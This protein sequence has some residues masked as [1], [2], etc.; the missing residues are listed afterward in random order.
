MKTSRC[1]N[2]TYRNHW[3]A[4]LRTTALAFCSLCC[5]T[6]AHADANTTTIWGD[7]DEFVRLVPQDTQNAGAAHTNAHPVTLPAKALAFALSKITFNHGGDEAVP[8]LD[9][10]AV[11][12]IAPEI[13]KALGR[14]SPAQDVTFAINTRAPGAFGG[15]NVVSVAGRVFYVDN[16]LQ[17]IVG[18]M[19]EST[20]SREF[21]RSPGGS[22]K[23][24]RRLQ[25]HRVGERLR[26][27]LH[28]GAVF[29]SHDGVEA[30]A[31]NGK[32]R[33]DWIAIDLARATQSGVTAPQTPR[34]SADRAPAVTAPERAVEPLPRRLDAE[35][36]LLQLERLR[37]RKLIT[38][39]EYQRKRKL[40]IDEL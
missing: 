33:A 27:T 1:P 31:V 18:E 39:E 35:E 14:A 3:L 36:R 4:V 24:D 30:V 9:N 25:P 28:D 26:E 10:N 2:L 34:G 38:E 5:I 16:R 37:E 20:V 8:L 23:I 21:F 13:S 22:L 6:L 17:M 12:R 15:S 11:K 32:T 29:D 19:H 7:D 40:I